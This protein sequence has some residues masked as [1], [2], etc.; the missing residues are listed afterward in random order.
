MPF[1][2]SRRREGVR[3]RPF[4]RMSTRPAEVLQLAPIRVLRLGRHVPAGAFGT[5]A[6]EMLL[7]L[8][9][10][11]LSCLRIDQAEPVLIDKHGLHAYPLLPGLF[12]YVFVYPFA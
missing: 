10:Q 9:G 6:E 1:S 4:R 3:R 7:D 8:F 5:F 12:G 2:A 11:I